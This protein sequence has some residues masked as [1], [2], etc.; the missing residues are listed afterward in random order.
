M[1]TW[2]IR[3]L[4][5]ERTNSLF[6]GSDKMA[7]VSAVYHSIVLTCKLQGYFILEYLKKFFAEIVAGNRYYG[8]LIPS[9]IVISANKL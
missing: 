4:A 6:F 9:I 3:S 1:G 2:C 5:N 8:K 7:R